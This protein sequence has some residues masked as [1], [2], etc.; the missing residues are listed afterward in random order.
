MEISPTLLIN[1]ITRERIQNGLE[2]YKLGF[3]QS[4]F[5][6]PELLTENLRQNAHQ[7][8]YLHPQGLIPL[9]EKIAQYYSERFQ[10]ESK[11]DQILVGP[12]SKE[13][14]FL[15]QL[16]A[17]RD[18]ILPS[19]NWV[20]YSPQANLIKK[21]THWIKT[22]IENKWNL[23]ASDLEEFLLKSG[24][25]KKYLLILNYP[26]NPTGQSFDQSELAAIA[27]IAYKYDLLIISDEIYAEFKFDN[28]HFSLAR[29]CPEKTI[30]CSGLSKWCGAGGWRL[31]YMIFNE[32]QKSLLQ[33][34]VAAGSET[35][36]CASAPI[37]YAAI[38]A[39]E[40][41]PEI[42]NYTTVC[43]SILKAT[44]D[45]MISDLDRNKIEYLPAKGG[46]YVFIRFKKPKQ[47]F[48]TDLELCNQLLKKEGVALLPGSCFGYSDKALTARLSFVDFPNLDFN[49]FLQ[50]PDLVTSLSNNYYNYIK[51]AIF[52]INEY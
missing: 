22:K 31:G 30:I 48:L 41:G 37:Q 17:D 1:N 13:L 46:F 52:R 10:V 28:N 9:R 18:L 11:E 7:K 45:R 51:T 26:N 43:R 39:F 27:E 44:H 40:N 34:I 21:Q 50:N 16:M 29:L 4:P 12:G 23:S 2:T 42:R 38:S 47:A 32:H 14:L 15:T 36:S 25:D 19:P 8:D 6:V 35:Y 24:K 49:Y 33:K 20:S 3:G 5:P